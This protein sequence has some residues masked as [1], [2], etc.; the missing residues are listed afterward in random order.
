MYD[1]P[2]ATM[3]STQTT[4][5]TGLEAFPTSTKQQKKNCPK[6]QK[7]GNPGNPGDDGAK[8]A[9]LNQPLPP[10]QLADAQA[11]KT[12][13]NKKNKVWKKKGGAPRGAQAATQ[14]NQQL[15]D[16]T[17]QLKGAED[18]LKEVKDEAKTAKEEIADVMFP[19]V[20]GPLGEDLTTK[21]TIS[22]YTKENVIAD[23]VLGTTLDGLSDILICDLDFRE[24]ALFSF[25][26]HTIRTAEVALIY[27]TFMIDGLLRNGAASTPGLDGHVILTEM[28]K[29]KD[30]SIQEY[31]NSLHSSFL[32]LRATIEP[33]ETNHLQVSDARPLFDRGEKRMLEQHYILKPYI[34]QKIDASGGR[35]PQIIDDPLAYGM[36]GWEH[37]A[38]AWQRLMSLKVP[39]KPK[40]ISAQ[41]LAELV[42]RRTI[43]AGL[44]N[45]KA[46]WSRMTDIVERSPYFQDEFT[47][48]L[49]QGISV[50]ADTRDIAFSMVTGKPW[51]VRSQDF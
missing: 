18:A 47:A 46:C 50:L 40:I 42:N 3:N 25:C 15:G 26:A 23:T 17:A 5:N 9:S 48:R 19:Y 12:K 51:L 13:A 6:Q 27:S 1:T 30:K 21:W 44:D 8:P 11:G 2:L 22:Q 39:F 16:M 32:Q 36:H 10:D 35:N 4:T 38:S 29:Q 28:S 20:V 7:T 41:L 49:T 24:I 31:T 33:Y 45:P 34:L 14:L 37:Q 43:V